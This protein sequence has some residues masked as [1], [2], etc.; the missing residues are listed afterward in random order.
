MCLFLSRCSFP[1]IT[2]WS[3]ALQNTPSDILFL[4]ILFLRYLSEV[5]VVDASHN[6]QQL[7]VLGHFLPNCSGGMK[8]NYTPA[9]HL[10]SLLVA[11]FTKATLK[12]YLFLSKTL[13]HSENLPAAGTCFLQELLVWRR[14]GRFPRYAV[15]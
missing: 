3:V 15:L 6:S 5:G 1:Y 2:I 9:I 7:L 8:S 13:L 10:S 12:M 4:N 14:R 11:D